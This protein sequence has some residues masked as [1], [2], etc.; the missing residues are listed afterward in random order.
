MEI[1]GETAPAQGILGGLGMQLPVPSPAPGARPAAALAPPQSH[2]LSCHCPR[3]YH[4]C[5]HWMKVGLQPWWGVAL[6]GRTQPPQAPRARLASWQNASRTHPG[7]GGWGEAV[8]MRAVGCPG[9]WA[10]GL[11]CAQHHPSLTSCWGQLERKQAGSSKRVGPTV[12]PSL[13]QRRGAT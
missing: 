12:I 3:S 8:P 6:R 13:P 4:C 11:S 1:Y 2:Q 5:C 9:M 10:G 7:G